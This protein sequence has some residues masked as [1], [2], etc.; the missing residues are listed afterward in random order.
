MKDEL[1]E[2]FK[3]KRV[4]AS[5]KRDRERFLREFHLSRDAENESDGDCY[6]RATRLAQTNKNRQTETRKR[7]DDKRHFNS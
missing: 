6:Y 3:L 2:M 7:V 4:K 1:F 5:G